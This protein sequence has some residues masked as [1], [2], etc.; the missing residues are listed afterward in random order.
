MLQQH[1]VSILLDGM[2]DRSKDLL[3][4]YDDEDGLLGEELE[5]MKGDAMF[6]S[7]YASLNTTREYHQ[8]FPVQNIN[9]T[10]SVEVSDDSVHVHFSGEEV[11][12]KY[13]DL[14]ACYQLFMNLPSCPAR[15]ADYLQYLDMF[16]SFFAMPAEARSTKA[17][18]SYLQELWN[19]LKT[20]LHRV[21]PLINLSDLEKTWIASFKGAKYDSSSEPLR[22][23]MFNS[24]DELEA[25]GPDRLQ[26]AL[27]AIGLKA[28]GTVRDR[29][30]VSTLFTATFIFI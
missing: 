3:K 4:M 16:A 22:L 9:A 13:L 20:F 17:Y 14:H 11:Y 1:K 25:L 18:N 23:G 15:G 5:S 26:Q 29:A 28:G 8:R 2:V 19:Y 30:E 10:S 6:S 12:G 21:Q 27:T 24:V 7:F